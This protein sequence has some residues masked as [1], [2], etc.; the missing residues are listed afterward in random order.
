MTT[1]KDIA[2]KT[3]T[4]SS[5]V[6]RVLN[7]DP[8]LSLTKQKRLLIKKVADELGYRSPRQ[9]KQESQK[10]DHAIAARTHF[11][12]AS[13][14]TLNLVVVHSLS[15]TEELNDPYFTSIRIGI[16]NRCHHF[17]ISLRNT[18]SSHLKSNKYFLQHAQAVICVGHFSPQDID[19]IYQ[20]NRQLIFI[21]SN[22]LAQKSDSVL[23]DRK[24][25]A[26][27]LVSNIINSG[28]KRPAFIGNDEDRLHVFR[29]LTQKNNIYHP[30]LC[31]VSQLFC[32]E[33]GYNAMSELL[34]QNQWPDVV[35]AATDI[36]AIG[37]YRAIQER[38]IEIPK[39]IKVISMNDIPTAQHLNPSLT[40]MRL[41]ATEMGESAVD[42]FLELV[43]GRQ[44]KK[45]V[46]LGYEMIWRESFPIESVIH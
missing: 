8:S 45:S 7:N 5:T 27:E 15:P 31:K 30:E 11:K 10:E 29:N 46:L 34:D 36:I 1:V 13:D 43:A 14:T 17:N 25:A 44:Y 26:T 39:E 19:S 3:G 2:Q 35:F 24:A 18:F 4:S 9:R 6:S 41:F 12:L 20:Q 16:E 22:P 40:T 42:L 38:E 32:I 33:S 28:A 21:D 23:F 37:V